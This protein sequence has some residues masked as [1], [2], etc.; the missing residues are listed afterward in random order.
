M[1]SKRKAAALALSLLLLAGCGAQPAQS[2]VSTDAT[3]KPLVTGAMYQ[4]GGSRGVD[5]SVKGETTFTVTRNEQGAFLQAIDLTDGSCVPLCSQKGCTHSGADCPAWVKEQGTLPY[6]NCLENGD[7]VLYYLTSEETGGK[8]AV[9]LRAADGTLIQALTALPEEGQGWSP[10]GFYND[11]KDLYVVREDRWYQSGWL[12]L[13]RLYR[14]HTQA[15]DAFASMEEAASWQLENTSILTGQTT[16]SG[17]LVC[18]LADDGQILSELLWNGETRA[19][20]QA[21]PQ[22]VFWTT[23]YSGSLEPEPTICLYDSVSGQLERLDPATG[24]SVQT[25]ALEP[26]LSLAGTPFWL[27]DTLYVGTLREGEEEQAFA[28]HKDG[29]VEPIT[30]QTSRNGAICPAVPSAVLD[31]RLLVQLSETMVETGYRD[32]DGKLVS[33]QTSEFRYGLFTPEQYLA[34]DAECLPIQGAF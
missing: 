11:G 20:R 34:N 9:E 22:Q 23:Q 18:Q 31:G 6:V 32:K 14:I 30:R 16:G 19:I 21:Q 1:N 33:G 4:T 7:L 15:G 25:A 13:Y 12:P 5:W 26:G 24:E 10:S 17:L 28:I 3:V 27:E 29:T 8:A 2:E